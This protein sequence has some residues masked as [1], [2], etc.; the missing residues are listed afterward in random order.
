MGFRQICSVHAARRRNKLHHIL[1]QAYIH[2]QS[3]DPVGGRGS[4]VYLS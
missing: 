4:E 1:V 3:V 2:L